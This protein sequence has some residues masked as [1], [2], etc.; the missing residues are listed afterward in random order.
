MYVFLKF[1]KWFQ[2]MQVLR[3]MAFLSCSETEGMG[4]FLSNEKLLCQEKFALLCMY[5]LG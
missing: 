3:L 4:K 1:N 2:D 5:Q